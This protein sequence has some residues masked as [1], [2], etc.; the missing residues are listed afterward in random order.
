MYFKVSLFLG[1]NKVELT[2]WQVG[3]CPI[4]T[5]TRGVDQLVDRLVWDQEATGSSPVTPTKE[6]FQSR[7][8]VG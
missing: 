8:S 1:K 4:T 5:Q 2:S 6:F 7:S 3:S